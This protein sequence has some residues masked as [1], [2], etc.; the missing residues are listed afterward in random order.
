MSSKLPISRL[1]RDLTEIPFSEVE[2]F[3]LQHG[4]L[5]SP[6]EN[7]A[8]VSALETAGVAEEDKPDGGGLGDQT[9]TQEMPAPAEA[10]LDDMRT[11][12]TMLPQYG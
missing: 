9:I 3:L 2:S 8:A 6:A 1:Q 7:R 10:G 12:E 5:S 11:I 4:L